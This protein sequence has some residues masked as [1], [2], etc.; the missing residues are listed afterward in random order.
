MKSIYVFLIIFVTSS[1]AS[2]CTNGIEWTQLHIP[3]KSSVYYNFK[4]SGT[5]FL[6]ECFGGYIWD[7]FSGHPK[8]HIQLIA[9]LNRDTFDITNNFNSTSSFNFSVSDTSQ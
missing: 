2:L 7:S 8:Y 3:A 4:E 1:F 6:L 9:V 5:Q